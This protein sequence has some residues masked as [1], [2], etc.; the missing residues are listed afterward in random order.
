MP[1]KVEIRTPTEFYEKA[2][3]KSLLEDW[4]EDSKDTDKVCGRQRGFE[5]R[6]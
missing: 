6:K 5:V 3:W 1:G 4:G 2:S